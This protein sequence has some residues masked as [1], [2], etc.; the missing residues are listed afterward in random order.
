MDISSAI[1]LESVSGPIYD[2][3]FEL[4]GCVRRPGWRGSGSR[5]PIRDLA[6]PQLDDS[7]PACGTAAI[8]ADKCFDNA[9]KSL[10]VHLLKETATMKLSEF[11]TIPMPQVELREPSEKTSKSN[12]SKSNTRN[13]GYFQPMFLQPWKDFDRHTLNT[14]YEKIL[15]HEQDFADPSRIVPS[16]KY[17]LKE[18]GIGRFID[19]TNRKVVEDALK[20]TKNILG[21]HEFISMVW[22]DDAKEVER[23]GR[24]K[25]EFWKPD[26]AGVRVGD[27]FE[28]ILEDLTNI[29]PGDTKDSR[30]WTFNDLLGSEIPYAV[31][32]LRKFGKFR[33][34]QWTQP[35]I[36]IF[37]YCAELEVRYG[38]LISDRELLVVRIRAY[39]K[40][41][42]PAESRTEV[43][44]PEIDPPRRS[45]RLRTNAKQSIEL[46]QE[47]IK[48]ED[49]RNGILEFASIKFGSQQED[50]LTVN[51][52]LWWLH[53]LALKDYTVQRSYK[54][55]ADEGLSRIET[56]LEDEAGTARDETGEDNDTGA[57]H[58]SEDGAASEG[59]STIADEPDRPPYQQNPDDQIY[60][61]F[62]TDAPVP[63]VADVRGSSLG[64]RRSMRLFLNSD[65]KRLRA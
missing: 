11:L 48:K 54:A 3:N 1:M 57:A 16:R 50:V 38:Y 47:T 19:N 40:G 49:I 56:R 44:H 4:I 62:R 22:G 41:E 58:E 10:W 25:N 8:A 61:S 59:S 60:S 6:A 30:A 21:R 17:A 42:T 39:Q 33:R 23:P 18:G 46:D 13:P 53:L 20:A 45:T 31:I 29:L 28:P 12:K 26:W 27:D 35:L 64:K 15:S 9:G 37:T 52:A 14:M 5:V 65:S 34:P 43:A 51:L 32:D 36:Q 7:Q 24:K 2:E 55:L 63:T